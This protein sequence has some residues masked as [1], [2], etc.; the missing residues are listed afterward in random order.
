MYILI[1]SCNSQLSK[2][3]NEINPDEYLVEMESHL[4]NLINRENQIKTE[5]DEN[6]AVLKSVRKLTSAGVLQLIE[7][8]GKKIGKLES[9]LNKIEQEKSK[10]ESNKLLIFDKQDNVEDIINDNLSTIESSKELL[11]KYINAFVHSMKIL[12]HNTKYTVL[13]VVIRDYKQLKTFSI[14]KLESVE[15]MKDLDY[16]ILDKTVT[17]DIKGGYYK[18]FKS[19]SIYAP[20]SNDD[21][22]EIISTIKNEMKSGVYKI[23]E[24]L[25]YKK[26]NY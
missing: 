22:N 24:E 26:L 8:T 21:L 9:D 1:Y 23:G 12:E 16:I 4:V 2:K 7:D 11:K 19:S 25:N 6:V 13:K 14:Y 18:R 15:I 3:I 17:R 5:I 20:L 10:I